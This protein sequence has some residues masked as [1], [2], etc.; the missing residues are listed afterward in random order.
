MTRGG[1]Q[2][3]TCGLELTLERSVMSGLITNPYFKKYCK[4]RL[5]IG[6]T[7]IR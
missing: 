7:I 5:Q 3:C 2:L 6:K 4:S 1:Y